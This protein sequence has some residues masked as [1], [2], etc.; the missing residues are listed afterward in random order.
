M[1]IRDR[2]NAAIVARDDAQGLVEFMLTD[3]RQRLDAV[4]RLDVLDAVAK[5]LLDSYAKEDLLTLDPDALGRRARV[6][7]LLGEVD[8]ARGNLDAALAR[9]KEAVATTEELL[10]RNPDDE[11]RIF[12]HAQSIYW[13]GDIAW[14][15]S[16]IHI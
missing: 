10:R 16:L 3:L 6:L 8:S 13:V 15:L 7:M 14:K 1:C 5:R 11:Q 9:Y 2:R 12:D 4:G